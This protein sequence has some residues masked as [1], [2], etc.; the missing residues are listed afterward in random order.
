MNRKHFL[1][2]LLAMVLPAMMLAAPRSKVQM[3]QI[4]ME[5]LSKHLPRTAN[6][7]AAGRQLQELRTADAYAIYGYREGGFVV[8]STDDSMPA[9]IGY[10]DSQLSEGKENTNFQWFLG[11]VERSAKEGYRAEQVL[12]DPNKYPD[13][14][15]AMVK[16][17]WG[18][19]TPYNLFTP[20]DSEQGCTLTG[21]VAVAMS[22]VMHFWR[23]PYRG[24]G[25]N[26]IYYPY[27]DIE[28][29]T[30]YTV[31]F[32]TAHYEWD[33][34]LDVYKDVAYT[35]EQAEAMATLMYHC[36]VACF[37]QY[38]TEF[39]G[40]YM[41]RAAEGLRK[42]FGYPQ[43]VKDLLRSSYEDQETWMDI[44]FNELA[45]GRPV[46]YGGDDRYYG[47]HAFV[48]D[49]YDA[50]GF[51][52]VNWG[53]EGKEDGFY[54]ITLLNPSGYNF[55][56]GHEMVIGIVPEDLFEPKTL[57]VLNN[58]A[59]NLEAR[60]G[61]ED[62]FAVTE[63]KVTGDINS[64]DVR[65][66]REM[67]GRNSTN[68]GTRGLLYKL[69]LS[70]ARFVSGGDP[71]LIDGTQTYTTANDAMPERFF[72]NCE[73]LTT[74]IL[75]ASM[76]HFASGA[77][78]YCY[79]LE[80]VQVPDAPQ[81]VV[82]DFTINDNGVVLSSDGKECIGVLPVEADT[83]VVPEGVEQLRDYA[84]AGDVRHEHFDLPSSLLKLGKRALDNENMTSLKVRAKVIPRMGEEVFGSLIYY[85][86]MLYVPAGTKTAYS[87]ADQWKEFRGTY[88]YN[89]WGYSYDNIREFGANVKARNASRLY[90]EEN[91][92]FG[93]QIQGAMIHGDPE[94]VCYATPES[95]VGRYTIYISRGTVVDDNVEFENGFLNVMPATLTA[96]AADCVRREGEDNP[97][98]K[99]IYTGLVNGDTDAD[100]VEKPVVTT[101]AT[102]DSPVGTYELIVSGGYADNYDFEYVAGT[103]T[104]VDATASD[105]KNV[106]ADDARRD[107]YSISGQRVA[108]PSSKGS[109]RPG[110]Y[111]VNGKKVVVK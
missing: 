74:L 34:M 17:K 11:E 35:Q 40:A 7:A 2:L 99:I 39:S 90:G 62:K 28:H 37:M 15:D 27:Y 73:G 13:H 10:S 109:L 32:G 54:D 71:Y 23:F 65:T 60:V 105:I 69:D 22:Q 26:T 79:G 111:I 104:I 64:D 78:A 75:P 44:L 29:A 108:V 110:V 102:K 67:A 6:G 81:G 8:V 97:E 87:N 77:F 107:V 33:K 61:S 89:Y 66:L 98:F 100:F 92:E 88:Y 106:N 93:Y 45:N 56:D 80:E 16:A 31:N 63:L 95:P 72:A 55:R 101:T 20:V 1:M 96:K 50:S 30:S 51:V 91:P 43:T 53:W 41:Q 84:L 59:G 57:E 3:Q 12:P 68:M 5:T 49:G 38:G 42:F 70:E 46:L 36:G 14:V 86:C 9:V 47:G 76:K 85:Y 48:I 83:L 94:I 103:L 24:Q 52:S 58:V 19:G 25:T 21:C 82:R 18:Q 4:A